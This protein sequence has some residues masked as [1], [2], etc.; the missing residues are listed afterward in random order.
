VR[1]KVRWAA[2]M[3]EQL[4]HESEIIKAANFWFAAFHFSLIGFYGSVEADFFCII[5]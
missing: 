5:I 3:A 4:W 2:A 1:S